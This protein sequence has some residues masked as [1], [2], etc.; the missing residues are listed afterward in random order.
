ML[1]MQYSLVSVYKQQCNYLYDGL[2]NLYFM[3]TGILTVK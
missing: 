1:A 3:K 2:K